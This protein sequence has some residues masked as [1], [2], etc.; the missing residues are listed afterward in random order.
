[1]NIITIATIAVFWFLFGLV[2]KGFIRGNNFQSINNA[3]LGNRKARLDVY[4]VLRWER[5]VFLLGPIGLLQVIRRS[6][7]Q[8]TSLSLSK[9]SLKRYKRV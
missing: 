2:A 3:D 6:L 8:G 9:F 4:H 7:W 1:M 5:V